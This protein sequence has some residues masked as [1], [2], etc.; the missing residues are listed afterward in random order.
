VSCLVN[1]DGVEDVA[2]ILVKEA[3]SDSVAQIAEG[4]C[5]AGK[6]IRLKTVSTHKKRVDLLKLLPSFLIAILDHTLPHL[7]PWSQYPR[8]V[9]QK[10]ALGSMIVTSVGGFGYI[11]VYNSFFGSTGSEYGRTS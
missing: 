11:D 6:G 3:D 8:I 5:E 7:T 10:D 2:I 9:V 4:I 1:S